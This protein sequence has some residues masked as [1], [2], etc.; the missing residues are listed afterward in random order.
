MSV[1]LHRLLAAAAVILLAG[2]V[3]SGMAQ[4]G[5]GTG[6]RYGPPDRATLNYVSRCLA[7]APPRPIELYSRGGWFLTDDL[8]DQLQRIATNI[9]TAGGGS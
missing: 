1:R 6:L 2:G 7:V 9:M 5:S 3:R 4:L 8:R